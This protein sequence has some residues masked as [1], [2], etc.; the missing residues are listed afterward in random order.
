MMR[1]ALVL[2]LVMT[3][4]YSRPVPQSY[5]SEIQQWRAHRRAR[6]TADDSWL[7]L[8]GLFWLHDGENEITLPTHPPATQKFVL[9]NGGVTLNGQPLRD[10]MD[11]KGPTVLRSGSVSYE[12]IKREDVSG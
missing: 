11:P 3:A 8:T 4:C 6:L 7:T 5:E 2:A 1:R 9:Q 12:V 10:D